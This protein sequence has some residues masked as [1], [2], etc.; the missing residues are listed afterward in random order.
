MRAIKSRSHGRIPEGFVKVI[1][2]ELNGDPFALKLFE[3]F[4]TSGSY[5]EDSASRF[6]QANDENSAAQKWWY[7]LYL[8]VRDDSRTEDITN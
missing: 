7:D 2:A 4:L 5:D 8:P 6:L 1:D 3:E